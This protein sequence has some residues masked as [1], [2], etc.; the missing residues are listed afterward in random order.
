MTYDLLDDGEDG[1][2]EPLD[3][4][5]LEL[6]LELRRPLEAKLLVEVHVH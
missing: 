1:E 6:L 3:E 5:V 2:G 4:C